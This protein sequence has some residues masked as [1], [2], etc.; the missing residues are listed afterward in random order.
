MFL[1]GFI[2]RRRSLV[3]DGQ[4]ADR[5][6]AAFQQELHLRDESFGV[7]AGVVKVG[8][9]DIQRLGRRVHEALAITRRLPVVFR[10]AKLDAE[11]QI[12]RIVAVLGQIDHVFVVERDDVCFDGTSMLAR[13]APMIPP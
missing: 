11:Q 9:K 6:D 2:V 8:Q 10:S 4:Q 1:P 7:W 12:N 5:F 3:R 13:I